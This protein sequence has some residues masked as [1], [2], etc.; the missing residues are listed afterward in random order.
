MTKIHP[1]PV[2]NGQTP[3][4][5]NKNNFLVYSYCSHDEIVGREQF[6][7]E[8]ISFGLQCKGDKRIACGPTLGSVPGP[9]EGGRKR[10]LI[11]EG[12][13]RP[14]ELFKRRAL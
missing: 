10:V 9:Q 11:S 6:K 4:Q 7:E 14:M 8:R 5:H 12:G 2:Q 3:K 1:I 13:D